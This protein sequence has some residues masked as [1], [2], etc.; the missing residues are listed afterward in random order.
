MEASPGSR[1]A[2]SSEPAAELLESG[3]LGFLDGAISYA[4]VQRRFGA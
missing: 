1:S 4:D 3:T 2:P